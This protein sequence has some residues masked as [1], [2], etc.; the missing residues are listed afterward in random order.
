MARVLVAVMGPIFNLVSATGNARSKGWGDN[1]DW[2][3]LR[4]GLARSRV[5][6]KPLMVVVHR[7]TCPACVYLKSRFSNSP[8]IASQSRHFVMVNLEPAETPS[9]DRQFHPD[10]HYVPRIFFFKPDGHLMTD[11]MHDPHSEY[12]YNY[13]NAMAI[14]NSMSKVRNMLFKGN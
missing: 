8:D 4:D 10:G 6:N 3:T 11:V 5:E 7:M 9:D 14:A 12:R 13:P 2:W 1:I